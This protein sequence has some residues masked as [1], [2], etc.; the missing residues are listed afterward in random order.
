MS[1][2]KCSEFVP[3]SPPCVALL[4]DGWLT[5]VRRC[6]SANFN[7]R[8]SNTDIELV[9]IHN[10]SLPP[11][12]FGGE[13]IDQLFTNRLDVQAHPFFAQL[14]GLQVSAHLLIRR[15]GELVQYVPMQERAWHAG[16]S[17]FQER[18]NCNDFAIGIELEGADDT[19]YEIIQYQQL[20][21]VIWALRKLYP[22]L[23][24]DRLVGH[25]AIA[26]GRKT[27]PGAAFDWALLYRLL[28]D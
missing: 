5:G 15:N 22:H 9:V 1:S 27:D 16:M 2:F 3:P 10:I 14:Q 20:A 19:P 13:Y 25:S 6:V 4:P 12:E 28:N 26:P 8:P 21:S 11:G 23:T 17:S 24:D 7:Q 18:P